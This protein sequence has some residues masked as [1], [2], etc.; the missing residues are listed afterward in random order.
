MIITL[1]F[2]Q[3]VFGLL[4]GVGVNGGMEVALR[5]GWVPQTPR[6]P[7]LVTATTSARTDAFTGAAAFG[8]AICASAGAAAVADAAAATAAAPGDSP[9][10]LHCSGAAEIERL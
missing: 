1:M 2:V 3:I 8:C 5:V 4:M 10:A 9:V 7:G 6:P